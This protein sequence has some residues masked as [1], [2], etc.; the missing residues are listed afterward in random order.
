MLK[1][2]DL[3]TLTNL[4]QKLASALDIR[5][6]EGEPFLLLFGQ[7]FFLGITM[8]TF[9]TASNT[10]FL[11]EFG[12]EA[13]PYVYLAAALVISIV[14]V[15]FSQ[16]ER[17]LAL[18]TLLIMTMIFMLISSL[19]LWAGIWQIAASWMIFMSMVWMRVIWVTINLVLWTLLGRMFNVRQ[20]K[21]LFSLVMAGPVLAFILIGLTTSTLIHLFGIT[22]LLFLAGISFIPALMLLVIT[23]RKYHRILSSSSDSDISGQQSQTK[24]GGYRQLFFSRYVLIFFA[25]IALSTIST[26]ILDFGFVTEANAYFADGDSLGTFFG[27]YLGVST[28]ALL[29]LALLSSRIFDR[30]GVSAGLLFNPM[31]VGVGT[32]IIAVTLIFLGSG[33]I[34]FWLVLMTKL[35]DDTLL[36]LNNSGRNLLY[37]PLRTSQ[38]VKAQTAAE[39]IVQPIFVGVVGI[40]LLGFN[41]LSGFGT[42]F[43]YYLLFISIVLWLVI[44]IWLKREYAVK[45]KDALVGHH[46]ERDEQEF[47]VDG[48]GISLLQEGLTNAHAGVVVYSFDVLLANNPESLLPML[49]DLLNHPI[50]EVRLHVLKNIEQHHLT[51]AISVVKAQLASESDPILQSAA[52]R[53]L[54]ALGEVET[55]A[56]YLDNTN[57]QI[58]FSTIVGLLLHGGLSGML[59]AGQKLMPL[60]TSSQAEERKMAAR[61]LGEVGESSFYQPIE[62][63]LNDEDKDVQQAAL[64]SAA[65]LQNPKL[66]PAIIGKL[67]DPRLV[68][69]AITTLAGGGK[70]LVPL[71]DEQMS[72]QPQ[73]RPHIIR[74]LG[75][76]KSEQ[77][78]IALKQLLETSPYIERGHVFNALHRHTYQAQE[79]D[80]KQVW[81]LIEDEVK[82]AIW[83][84]NVLH[85]L[86]DEDITS[87]ALAFLQSTIQHEIEQLRTRILRLL[88]FVYETDTLNNI[89]E[90]L[91]QHIASERERANALEMLDVLLPQNIKLRIFPLLRQQSNVARLQQLQTDTPM[92]QNWGLGDLLTAS[93]DKMNLWL[94]TCALHA[95]GSSDRQDLI[96]LVSVF[97]D[98]SDALVQETAIWALERLQANGSN[99]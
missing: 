27:I 7:A 67:Q 74:I 80:V 75:V 30:F 72:I 85:G 6:G 83:L 77:A 58:Q 17:H 23:T 93:N 12:A 50:Q 73:I 11:V 40:M 95:V 41:S 13:F 14:G 5:E 48:V 2:I 69:S 39:S 52:L 22:H 94:R 79:Q 47:I 64:Q 61:V 82:Q 88:S 68:D 44:A 9:F 46:L 78:L 31:L 76:M 63:L 43:I 20:G 10:L 8:G 96:P 38:R 37:Q 1:Q 33:E 29:I 56:L 60:I 34:I 35:I 18:P 90:I 25:F 16:L 42:D 19:L 26:Y 28:F 3:P 53:T 89:H 98:N 51:T 71:L 99:L 45:L 92:S 4:L 84:L 87:S 36:M 65:Q 66:W 54:A 15:V 86:D 62:Q 91:M 57:S 59:Q 24:Q 70:Q 97:V 55:V 81:Q 32:L 21:R 49:P